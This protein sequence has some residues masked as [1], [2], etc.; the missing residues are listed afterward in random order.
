MSATNTHRITSVA[1]LVEVVTLENHAVL[2]QD[3]A[4][5]LTIIAEAK[6]LSSAV[7]GKEGIKLP[8]EFNWFDDGKND[9]KLNVVLG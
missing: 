7:E 6:A 3:I 9:V 2:A 8:T 5:F 4:H 1:D